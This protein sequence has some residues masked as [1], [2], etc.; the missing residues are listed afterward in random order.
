MLKIFN[1]KTKKVPK[2]YYKYYDFNSKGNC[3]FV[4][5]YDKKGNLSWSGMFSLKS[6]ALYIAKLESKNRNNSKVAI[7]KYKK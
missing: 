3:Y 7:Q 4:D 2:K 5:T 6:D 1:L